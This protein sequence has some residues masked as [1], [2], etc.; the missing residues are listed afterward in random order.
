MNHISFN[1]FQEETQNISN[2]HNQS[3]L[4]STNNLS[5]QQMILSKFNTIFNLFST[6]NQNIDNIIKSILH[7]IVFGSVITIVTNFI[8]R[9]GDATLVWNFIKTLI[10]QVFKL[11]KNISYLIKTK[12]LRIRDVKKINKQVDIPYISDNKQINEL[13]KAVYWY[14]TNQTSEIDYIKEP[15]LQFI[16]D[17]KITPTSNNININ[18]IL[19]QYKKKEIVFKNQKIVYVLSTDLITVYT[20]KDRKRENY[21]ITLY[22]TIT[23]LDQNDILEEFCHHCCSTYRD[24]L[25]SHTWNQQIFTNKNGQWSS[26]PSNNSRKLDTIILKN[27]LKDIIKTDLQLFLNKGAG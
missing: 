2:H 14:L 21:K 18:K 25:T 20:D 12:I 6:G 3:L 5:I 10:Y 15:Y 27:N 9:L 26:V 8:T 11:V 4:T 7:S 17:K 13:Y 23:E 24:S 22:A 1:P 16:Y 19:T